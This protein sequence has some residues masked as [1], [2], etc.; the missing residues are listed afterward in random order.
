VYNAEFAEWALGFVRK[1]TH[2]EGRWAGQKFE[3][4]P[5]QEKIICDF[6]G[7][8]REDN[9][10]KRRYRY[11]YLE[12]PK[13]NGKSGLAAALGLYHL[14][15]DG[16]AA[17]EVYICAADRNQASIIYRAAQA[18]VEADPGLDAAQGGRLEV[19]KSNREIHDPATKS[20]LRVM[21][22]DAFTKHGYKPSAVIFDELHAQPKRDLW[23]VMTFGA[24]DAREQ[25]VWIVLTTAGK[26]P[27]RTSIGWEIHKQALDIK[28][29]LIDDDSWYVALY[30]A[31]DTVAPAELDRQLED[32]QVWY[33]ANPSLGI[34]IDIDTV[35]RD[36]KEAQRNPSKER[37]FRWLRLNQWITVTDTNWLPLE[38]F[39]DCRRDW[40]AGEMM[41]RLDGSGKAIRGPKC[42]LG[43]D[44]GAT[45]D[46]SAAVLLFPPEGQREEWRK[47]YFC[48]VPSAKVERRTVLDGA[49]YWDWAQQGYITVTEGNA[50]DYT[51]IEKDLRKIFK[52][53][54]VEAAGGDQ[55]NSRHMTQLLQIDY[56]QIAFM[57]IPQTIAG[58]S[59][60]I[61]QSTI[62]A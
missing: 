22:A 35:R 3:P 19:V 15:A 12:A 24:G 62:P 7:T 38:V 30:G 57:E 27:D 9:P 49:N 42:F 2:T 14:M 52:Y 54:N 37:L 59:T 31:P 46:L 26:D 23:D 60:A 51:R 4:L 16:E 55:W 21:S 20:L 11:L 1:L 44:L 41:T 40:A 53:Y 18:M 56:D 36:A 6:Y 17:A 48:W 39:D 32:E 34:L 8:V 5:W 28:N 61:F 58:M 25:P 29:G 13:K 10:K 33:D 45:A 50:V 43:F 47:I